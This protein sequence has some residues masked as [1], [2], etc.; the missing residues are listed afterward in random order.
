MWNLEIWFGSVESGG[1]QGLVQ[2]VPPQ[3]ETICLALL[4]AQQ[5]VLGRTAKGIGIIN[6]VYNMIQRLYDEQT[7]GL[8]L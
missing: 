3:S 2:V 1:L 8:A 6:S 4:V 5:S 7:T